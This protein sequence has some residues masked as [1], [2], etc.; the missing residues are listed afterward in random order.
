MVAATRPANR[1]KNQHWVP[2]FYLSYFATPETAGTQQPKAWIFSKDVGDPQLTNVRNIAAKR[3]LYSPDTPGCGR[4]W[5]VESAL[6]E[7]EDLLAPRWPEF[8]HGFVDLGSEWVRKSLALFLGTLMARH[9]SQI[10]EV[11]GLHHQLVELL[12]SCPKDANG[13][14]RVSEI[15]Y[16][17]KTL[18]FDASNYAE[19]QSDAPDHLHRMFVRQVKRTAGHIA[20]LLV[21]MRWA[22]VFAESP[23]FITTD[24]PAIMINPERERFGLR[25]PGTVVSL[26]LSPTR[27]LMID[28]QRDQPDANYYPLESNGPAPFNLVAWNQAS[29]FMISPR[30]PDEVC[31]ELL[32]LDT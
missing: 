27:I 24:R 18:P 21:E 10:A 5:T 30:H 6:G 15:E 22:V 13:N 12:E 16:K 19:Y 3:Y 26:P 9:P 25:T 20:R 17:G 4:D 2:Q 11:A 32:E 7:I 8:A 28:N 1:P 29:D 14:P 23:V 31:K